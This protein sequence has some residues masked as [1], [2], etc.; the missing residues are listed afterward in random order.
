MAGGNE[1]PRQKMI[2][3]M[4]LVLTALL[5]LQVSNT[6]LE[7]FIFIDQS[8]EQ[9]ADGSKAQNANTVDRIRS[10]VEE[11]GNR[12]ED[13]AVLEKAREVRA[14]T[15]QVLTVLDSLKE[16]FVV[17]TGGVD[18][19]G[20][21]KGVK[22]EDEIADLMVRQGKGEE[23]KKTLNGYASYL[24][25]VTGNEVAPIA[26]DARE[27]PVF[28]DDPEQNMKTFSEITF[29]STPMVAGLASLSQIKNEVLSRETIALDN[30]A[31]QVGA[32]DLKFD[33]IVAMVRPESNVVAAGTKYKADL[34]I[35]ASS[36]AVDPVMT[37]DGKEIPVDGGMGQIEFTAQAQ[38]Y[39]AD[40]KAEKAFKAAITIEQGG[41]KETYEET[42]NYYVTKPVI[43]VQSQSVQALYLNCGNELQVNVPALGTSYDP[44]FTAKGGTAIE[45]SK[46]GQVTIIPKS[47]KVTLSVSS[48]GYNIGN[49][50]FS[51]RRVP[52]PT[53][54]VKGPGGGLV[55]MQKG[56]TASRLRSIKVE[57]QPDEDFASF[58]PKDARYRV[59]DAEIILARGSRPI[60][61]ATLTNQTANLGRL[62]SQA[63][64]GD[65]LV[66]EVKKV[67]RANF[68][69]EIEDVPMGAS[70]RFINVPLN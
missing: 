15:N 13:V 59:A 29:Q 62:M 70:E 50:T 37:V 61:K 56:E 19:D 68:R 16:K 55:N 48:G 3:M 41:K 2:G 27:N 65:R 39:D 30:L 10:A 26:L 9:S 44:N 1:S 46:T 24:T 66:I 67:Q 51:V 35:A 40:N 28:K 38:Q 23:L 52:K 63:K 32:A 25:G 54:V 43:Q 36:S 64:S 22:N 18:E 58:L 11:A 45:G 17:M 4:Y 34:F 42:F 33:N 49:E 47:P 6:V 8:L 14:Q 7:K 21:Y 57:A 60:G 5:A 69:N 31:R 20:T 53:I 12:E